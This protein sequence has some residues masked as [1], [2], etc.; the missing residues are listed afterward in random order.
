MHRESIIEHIDSFPWVS[1]LVIARRKNG[2]LRLCVDLKSVNEAVIP[3]R[4]PLPTINELSAL[5]H[6]ST[7]FTKLDE[8][9]LPTLPL[10]KAEQTFDYIR[11]S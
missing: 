11:C 4:Y 1:N 9:K 2:E 3:D 5:F 10:S 8:E 6:G 7:V